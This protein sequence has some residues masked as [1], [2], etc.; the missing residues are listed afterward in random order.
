LYILEQ[1]DKDDMIENNSKAIF[2]DQSRIVKGINPV[3]M[4]L[5]RNFKETKEWNK[6]ERK[7]KN[8]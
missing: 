4:E 3:P 2:G 6:K 7:S 1:D 5:E 8:F